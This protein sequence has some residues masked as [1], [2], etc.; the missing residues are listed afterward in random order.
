M[1]CRVQ[2]SFIPLLPES[3]GTAFACASQ[4]ALSIVGLRR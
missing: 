3:V 1:K 2:R 4:N